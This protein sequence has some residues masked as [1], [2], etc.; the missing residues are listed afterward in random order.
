LAS[1][2][3]LSGGKRDVDCRTQPTQMVRNFVKSRFSNVDTG[4]SPVEIGGDVANGLAAHRGYKISELGSD[5]VLNRCDV[6][7]CGFAAVSSPL[8]SLVLVKL[9]I[10]LRRSTL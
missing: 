8:A 5:G 7:I 2:I 6:I 10:S 4:V 1:I 9:V 3:E